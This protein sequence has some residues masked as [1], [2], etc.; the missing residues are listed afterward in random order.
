M[1]A[2][3]LIPS[4]LSSLLCVVAIEFSGFTANATVILVSFG[5]T[6]NGVSDNT[7]SLAGS[8]IVANV[9]TFTG[10]FTYDTASSALSQ[11]ATVASYPGGPLVVTIDGSH[12]FS[13]ADQQV[14]VWNDDPSFQDR[15][16]SVPNGA[17]P[18]FP[19]AYNVNDNLFRVS[20]GDPTATALANTSLP[21]SLSLTDFATR[22]L[23]I[24]TDLDRAAGQLWS[25]SGRLTSLTFT[26]VP[27]PGTALLIGLGVAGLA[28]TRR[29][30]R[31]N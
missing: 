9:S 29:L 5:G 31:R 19:F 18:V 11:G 3:K 26:V 17:P 1:N 21:T 28:A 30:E 8:N 10:S 20:L 16:E 25:I 24:R 14:R 22:D 12:A 15:F 2:P 4:W 6:I 13:D 7:G 27:E 23:F